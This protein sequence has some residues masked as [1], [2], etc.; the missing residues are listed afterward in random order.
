MVA[1]KTFIVFGRYLFILQILK[2]VHLLYV[3]T[4]SLGYSVSSRRFLSV[5]EAIEMNLFT[6]RL[7]RWGVVGAVITGPQLLLHL[8]SL[9][10]VEIMNQ[11]KLPC[12]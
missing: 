6:H 12:L 7:M 10:L 1:A 8:H 11:I 4:R 5:L 3:G 2:V 9:T